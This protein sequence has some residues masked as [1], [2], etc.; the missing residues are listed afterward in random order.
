[1][2]ALK[3]VNS[4]IQIREVPG[5]WDLFGAKK[6]DVAIQIAQAPIDADERVAVYIHSS[7][8]TGKSCG[9]KSH[10]RGFKTLTILL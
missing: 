5:L 7:G 9:L 2:D 1:V 4:S 8:T 10:H 3:E 6:S